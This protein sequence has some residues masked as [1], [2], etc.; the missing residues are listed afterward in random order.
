MKW[1]SSAKVSLL[2]VSLNEHF[3]V[4]IPPC[5]SIILGLHP[6]I[7]IHELLESLNLYICIQLQSIAMIL[8]LA[9]KSRLIL[10]RHVNSLQL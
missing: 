6:D 7:P 2:N 9:I 3:L 4:I 1:M 10:E 8:Q 5:I